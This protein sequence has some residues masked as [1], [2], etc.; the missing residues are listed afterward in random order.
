[1]VNDVMSANQLENFLSS[2]MERLLLKQYGTWCNVKDIQ[3]YEKIMGHQLAKQPLMTKILNRILYFRCWSELQVVIHKDTIM[4]HCCET[5]QNQA[6][7][8][9]AVRILSARVLALSF[10]FKLV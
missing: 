10:P 1:M 9:N 7:Q 8:L 2:L 4:W 6:A 3:I 5:L